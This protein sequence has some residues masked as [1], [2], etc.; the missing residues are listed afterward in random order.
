MSPSVTL[1]N[2]MIRIEQKKRG[3]KN[4][5]LISS[6][7]ADLIF[8]LSH[9]ARELYNTIHPLSPPYIE[10]P[11]YCVVRTKS[12]AERKNTY[13]LPLRLAERRLDK[14]LWLRAG[15]TRTPLVNVMQLALHNAMVLRDTRECANARAQS[16]VD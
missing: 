11:E 12:D 14:T 9:K 13:L 16:C 15:A 4:F 5:C 8:L 1:F 10:V 3:T 6:S 2:N 7:I